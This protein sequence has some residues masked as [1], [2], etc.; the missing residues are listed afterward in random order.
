MVKVKGNSG[1]EFQV[2]MCYAV[3]AFGGN[4]GDNNDDNG[5][6]LLFVTRSEVLL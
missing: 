6:H 1:M 4:D 3:A 5:W 2:T